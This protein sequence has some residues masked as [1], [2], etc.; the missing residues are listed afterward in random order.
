MIPIIPIIFFVFGLIIGSFLNVV[1]LRFN[2]EKSFGGRSACMSCQS[3]L[4][5]YELIPVFS[6]LGLGG[7]CSNCKTRISIQYPLVE[8]FTGFVFA[9]LF[10][11][12]QEIFFFSTPVFILTYAYYAVA[13]S[14]L[15]IVAVYDIR[16]KIIPDSL[17]LTLGIIGFVG[18]FLFNNSVFYPHIPS[19]LE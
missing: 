8:L 4:A 11:K 15:I 2:T 12:F 1:I 18:L 6:F 16:H 10:L 3:A 14:I 7:R 9:A 13:F 19:L 5:W 17:A